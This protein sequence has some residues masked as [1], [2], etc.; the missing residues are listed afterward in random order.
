MA[1]IHWPLSP[2]LSVTGRHGRGGSYPYYD[3]TWNDDPSHFGAGFGSAGG[4][5]LFNVHV[6][7]NSTNGITTFR[8][9]VE[10]LNTS[11]QPTQTVADV[12]HT[13]SN[14][15]PLDLTLS[16]PITGH[17]TRFK[18]TLQV[19]H[20][21]HYSQSGT[22]WEEWYDPESRVFTL[23]TKLLWRILSRYVPIT[24]SIARQGRT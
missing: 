12:E 19:F 15:A 6:V 20:V 1:D 2:L 9:W 18:V 22:G 4:S 14:G 23:F 11:N 13:V 21:Y 10:K 24:I 8:I 16:V 3:A 17:W 5:V 7:S